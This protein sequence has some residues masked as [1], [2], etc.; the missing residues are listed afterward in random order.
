MFEQ[1]SPSTFG[2]NSAPVTATMASAVNSSSGPR[3]TASK[4]RRTFVV[5]NQ[6]VGGSQ[7]GTVHGA[8]YGN[9]QVVITRSAEILDGGGEPRLK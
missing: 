7:C 4:N 2:G 5:P 1:V 9:T 3:N 8:G 6:H